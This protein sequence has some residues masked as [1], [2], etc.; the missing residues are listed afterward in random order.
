MTTADG[1]TA[2]P[3]FR[4]GVSLLILFHLATLFVAPM[5]F[6]TSVGSDGPSPL[7][8]DV[9]A[10]FQSYSHIDLAYLNHGYYFFAPDPGPN[11]LVEY[12]LTFADG[13]AEP[14]DDA[15]VDE[16]RPEV[17]R[18]PDRERHWPRLLYHRHFM[19]SEWLHNRYVPPSPPDVR[20][21]DPA[22]L[23]DWKHHRDL[24]V[25][26]WE[27]YREHLRNES[28]ATTVTLSRVEHRPPLVMEVVQGGMG[29]NDPALYQTFGRDDAPM[30]NAER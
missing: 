14:S 13:N 19:L 28:G 11:H 20:S 7:A 27:S 3:W 21:G 8:E 1:T 16:R 5:A 18:F 29:L 26:T 6:S 12:Q 10:W 24:Y 30:M 17:H 4:R 2:P 22:A 9:M 25:Q 23:D 15:D